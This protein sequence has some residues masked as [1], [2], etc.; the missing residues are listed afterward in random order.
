[1]LTQRKQRFKDSKKKIKFCRS[2][3]FVRNHIVV[4]RNVKQA[5][6][7]YRHI[8]LQPTVLLVKSPLREI[9]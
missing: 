3:R 4:I 2:V 9:Q 5:E 6:N 1:M 7:I 8:N